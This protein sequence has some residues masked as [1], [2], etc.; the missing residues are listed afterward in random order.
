MH[1]TKRVSPI[2]DLL[3]KVLH[4][5]QKNSRPSIEEIQEIWGRVAGRKAAGHSWPRRLE[6]GRLIVEVENSGWIYT[7]NI[8]KAQLMQGLVELL[9]A[10][11]LRILSFRIGEKKDA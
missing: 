5:L 4:G 3:K 10:D 8:R 7:L 11:R 6:R 2:G 9:G 1:A